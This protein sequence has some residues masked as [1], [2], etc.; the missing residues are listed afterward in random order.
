[1]L[2]VPYW[3]MVLS[4]SEIKENAQEIAVKTWT[5]TRNK[6]IVYKFNLQT[7]QN[8]FQRMVYF[9]LTASFLFEMYNM[10]QLIGKSVSDGGLQ[11]K[12]SYMVLPSL[13]REL[14][15]LNIIDLDMYLYDITN[16]LGFMALLLLY[17]NKSSLVKVQRLSSKKSFKNSISDIVYNVILKTVA[18]LQLL[19]WLLVLFID[20]GYFN[21][22]HRNLGDWSLLLSTHLV[23]LLSNFREH[24]FDFELA[25]PATKGY[26]PLLALYFYCFTLTES[27]LD[28]E[29]AKVNKSI[30]VARE[31][32]DSL[33]PPAKK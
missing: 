31:I 8:Q 20:L 14:Q 32:V 3:T 6:L 10:H 25:S 4:A 15:R 9:V 16:T 5:Q 11:G 27:Y 33:V 24:V 26:L 2:L 21:V 22:L 18:R 7:L 1:M 23:P 13:S 28:S 29:E 12:R 19:S 17:T 30:D